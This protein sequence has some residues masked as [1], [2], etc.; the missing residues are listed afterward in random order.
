[1]AACYAP[2]DPSPVGFVKID[3]NA[4]TAVTADNVIR[5]LSGRFGEPSAVESGDARLWNLGA[6]LVATQYMPTHKLLSLMYMVPHTY[7][8]TRQ[9]Q[10][11]TP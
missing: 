11:K 7:Y 2:C 3:Y 10:E 5:M 6:V 9:P 4:A 8:L 1:M